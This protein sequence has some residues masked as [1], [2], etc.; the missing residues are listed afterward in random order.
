MSSIVKG[1]GDLIGSVLEIF[2]GIISTIVGLF[3]GVLNLFA[4]LIKNVFGAAEGLIGFVL[5]NIFIIGTIAAVFFAYVLYQQ[6]QGKPVTVGN[7]KIN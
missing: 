3:Q 2:K 6:R 1:V 4:D 5:G 7:K